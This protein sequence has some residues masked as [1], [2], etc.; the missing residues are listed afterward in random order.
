MSFF[1]ASIWLTRC[2]GH[3]EWQ[4]DGNDTAVGIG[5][6]V[7]VPELY[8]MVPVGWVQLEKRFSVQMLRSG[9]LAAVWH[10]GCGVFSVLLRSEPKS[11]A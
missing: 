8:Q 10:G 4:L 9:D 1:L 11:E 2:W 5:L 7:E 3:G 6:L